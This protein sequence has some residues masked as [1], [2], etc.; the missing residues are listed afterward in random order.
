MLFRYCWLRQGAQGVT[1]SVR[2]A[3]TKGQS[4]V[5]AYVNCMQAHIMP[6]VTLGNLLEHHRITDNLKIST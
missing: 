4:Q 3:Q 6:L 2:P 1:L 5:L